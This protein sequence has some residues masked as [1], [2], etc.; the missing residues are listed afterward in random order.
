MFCVILDDTHIGKYCLVNHVIAS[1]GILVAG[2]SLDHAF[3]G[4]ALNGNLGRETIYT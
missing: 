4:N 1:C 3:K 2:S